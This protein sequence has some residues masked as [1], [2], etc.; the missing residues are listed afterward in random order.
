MIDAVVG[1]GSGGVVSVVASGVLA[2]AVVVV[3]VVVECLSGFTFERLRS[4]RDLGDVG[5]AGA[6]AGGWNLEIFSADLAS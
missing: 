5:V 1:V 4:S 2:G 3:V 6:E